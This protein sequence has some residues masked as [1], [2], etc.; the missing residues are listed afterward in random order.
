MPHGSR[1][2]T[3]SP[4]MHI[5]GELIFIQRI[6]SL[7]KLGEARRSSCVLMLCDMTPKLYVSLHPPPVFIPVCE[8]KKKG[9]K[10]LRE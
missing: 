1:A 9:S 4:S 3:F 8:M 7:E 5:S 2:G 6:D 10:T